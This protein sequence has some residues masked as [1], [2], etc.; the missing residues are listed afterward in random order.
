MNNPK[1]MQ[2]V[3]LGAKLR[4]RRLSRELT[5]YAVAKAGGIRIDQV[6]VV[7]MGEANYTV[8]VLLGYLKGVGLAMDLTEDNDAL[9]AG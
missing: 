1:E 4:E 5:A 9:T 8:D 6:K 2:R 7:E 3:A